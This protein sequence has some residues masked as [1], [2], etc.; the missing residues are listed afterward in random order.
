MTTNTQKAENDFEPIETKEVA[1]D[2]SLMIRLKLYRA[3]GE[4]LLRDITPTLNE[5]QPGRVASREEVDAVR[6]A[7]GALVLLTLSKEGA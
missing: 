4:I 6:L 5:L 2:S 3:L 7:L 1:N